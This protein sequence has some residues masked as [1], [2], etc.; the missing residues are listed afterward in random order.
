VKR[1]LSR[2]NRAKKKKQRKLKTKNKVNF[3]EEDA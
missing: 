2:S 3:D 1:A